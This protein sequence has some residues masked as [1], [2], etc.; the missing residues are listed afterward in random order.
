MTACAIPGT[1]TSS[2]TGTEVT[3]ALL[4]REIGSSCR[5]RAVWV[6]LVKIQMHQKTRMTKMMMTM[7]LIMRK[8]V[9][10]AGEILT[11]HPANRIQSHMLC[12]LS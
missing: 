9:E 6:A 1:T 5:F 10:T 2:V 8:E 12:H 4:P 7:M 11:K 3:V